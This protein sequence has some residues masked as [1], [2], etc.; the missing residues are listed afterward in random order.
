MRLTELGEKEVIRR[1]S[2]FLSIGDDAAYLKIDDRYLVLSTD[3][4]YSETHLLPGISYEQIGKLIV[5]V[6]LSDI[7][8]MGAEPFAFLL[9][10][11]GPDDDF[12]NLE[13]LIKAADRQCK[14]YG[15]RYVGGDTKYAQK[16]TLTGTAAGF[17]K[18]PVLRSGAKVGDIIA[19]TGTLGGAAL[20][21]DCLL[22]GWECPKW[23]IRKA[24]EPEPRAKEGILLG[25]YASAM[26]DISD[27]L[28]TSLHDIAIQSHV[29]VRLLIDEIPLD[30]G[31]VKMAAD[32]G[33]DLMDYALYGGGDYELLFTAS[34]DNLELVEDGILVTRIGEVTKEKGVT[35]VDGQHVFP[36]EK[37]GYE[38][39]RG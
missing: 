9:A 24:L 5:T 19:V 29:G 36:L 30:E 18:R 17:T 21:V 28:S 15:T 38:H 16:M 39:F 12:K 11:G 27:S 6:N 22:R 34:G 32:L 13:A 31:A 10:Y 25:K 23:L 33:L 4:I 2:R 8:A 26:T 20:V 7:A 1:M 37:K 35:A 14:K 3:M